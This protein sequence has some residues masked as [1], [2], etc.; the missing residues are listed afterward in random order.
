MQIT[1]EIHKHELYKLDLSPQELESMVWEMFQE[2][3]DPD[4][5]IDAEMKITVW[6]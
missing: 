5:S 6:E 4:E 1:I 3:I 2:N